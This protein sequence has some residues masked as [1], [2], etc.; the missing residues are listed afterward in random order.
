MAETKLR[1][2]DDAGQHVNDLGVDFAT[3]RHG[4]GLS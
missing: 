2:P 1:K 4:G 3:S